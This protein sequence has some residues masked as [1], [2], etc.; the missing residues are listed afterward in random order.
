MKVNA[1]AVDGLVEGVCERLALAQK[2]E[3]RGNPTD[4]C[5][6]CHNIHGFAEN[7]TERAE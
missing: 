6:N 2:D 1:V 4:E 7:P 5:Q 3:E